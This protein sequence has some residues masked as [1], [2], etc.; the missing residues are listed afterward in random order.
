MSQTDKLLELLKSGR[1]IRTDFILENVYGSDHLGIARIGARIADLKKRGAKIEGR[2]DPQKPTLY[3]YK[4]TSPPLEKTST[5]SRPV[6]ARENDG[7]ARADLKSKPLI[8][9]AKKVEFGQKDLFDVNEKP[10]YRNPWD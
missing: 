7:Q 3:W 2:R 8:N 9:L 10:R 6:L 5:L 1:W 4:M